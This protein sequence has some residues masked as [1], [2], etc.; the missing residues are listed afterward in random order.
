MNVIFRPSYHLTKI[1][2]SGGKA[3]VAARKIGKPSHRALSFPNKRKI[4]KAGSERPTVKRC[5][6]PRFS[7]RLRIGG[8]RNTHDYALG[9]LNVPRYAT[10]G[11][12]QCKEV[13]Q[14]T[15]PPQSSVPRLVACESRIA[16]D[17]TLIVDAVSSAACPA[18]GRKAG[19]LITGFLLWLDLFLPTRGRWNGTAVHSDQANEKNLA[20]SFGCN[21]CSH[22]VSFVEFFMTPL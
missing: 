8:L 3:V 19:H 11:S 14:R 2:G 21:L 4:D 7:Q 10:I 13:E 6:T 12:P 16:C 5:A 9:I 18:Q 22:F 20:E 17:P 1:V 15:I